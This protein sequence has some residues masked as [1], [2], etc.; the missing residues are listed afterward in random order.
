MFCSNCGLKLPENIKFC[1]KCGARII[2]NQL[3]ER[4]RNTSERGSKKLSEEQ[5]V[6]EKGVSVNLAIK[7]DILS[8]ASQ[9]SQIPS[10][11]TGKKE[12]FVQL[13]AVLVTG[14][15]IGGMLYLWKLEEGITAL[16]ITALVLIALG[17]ILYYGA[18]HKIKR[19]YIIQE[20]IYTD[21]VGC[22]VNTP[23]ELYNML[24]ANVSGLRIKNV[25]MDA[26]GG[27]N[28]ER[29]GFVHNFYM[30]NG[31]AK[32]RY[33]EK[34]VIIGR[35]IYG[36]IR[37]MMLYKKVQRLMDANQIMDFL[38]TRSPQFSTSALAH[39][40]NYHKLSTWKKMM[41]VGLA[42][43]VLGVILICVVA[44][45]DTKLED[46]ISSGEYTAENESENAVGEKTAE[47]KEKTVFYYRALDYVTLG[48][49]S[50]LTVEVDKNDC[51]VDDTT[52]YNYVDQQIAEA[53][54]N[55]GGDH[56]KT[57]VGQGDEVLVDYEGK[58]DGAAF[59][60][61][62][63]S[64]V[65]LDTDNAAAYVEGFTDNLVGAYIGDTVEQEVTFPDNYSTPELAGKK[66]VF[67]FQVKSVAEKLTHEMVDD[68]FI[69]D[70]FDAATLEEFIANARKTLE[71]EA[72]DN[73]KINGMGAAVL[74]VGEVSSFP[75]GVAEA[76]EESQISYYRYYAKQN[77]ISMEE[78]ANT[79]YSL[80]EEELLSQTKESVQQNLKQ[81]LI[82]E[83][84][85]ERE[86]LDNRGFQQY[87]SETIKLEG[88]NSEKEYY[89][90]YGE[91]YGMD[92]ELVKQYL[93][94][95]Y[96]ANLASDYL[97]ERAEISYTS[98]GDTG[99]AENEEVFNNEYTYENEYGHYTENGILED[100]DICGTYTGAGSLS[101]VTINIYTSYDSEYVGNVNGAIGSTENRDMSYSVDGEI[102]KVTDNVYRL[103]TQY[104]TV[105]DFCTYKND[106]EILIDVYT[107]GDVFATLIM[108][109]HYD[110]P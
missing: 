7:Q 89:E 99:D 75:E 83:A 51:T 19:E 41:P 88:I 81:Q 25:N 97:A 90:R 30:E 1:P 106:G 39:T 36:S 61:G 9:D 108:Q 58:I 96:L 24:L 35:S 92:E 2:T 28:V 42:S 6:Q 49:Y 63:A 50:S 5:A 14:A 70:N 27:V 20:Q 31:T 76:M 34:P 59:E 21:G 3:D 105:Y 64:D 86:K 18:Y 54:R 79:Y 48:D 56:A 65:W 43:I 23:V 16:T 104:G 68:V 74:K 103:E 62:S 26:A 38:V 60:G 12:Y 8:M 47:T 100:H 33:P 29:N 17:F 4:S 87:L 71:K 66:A 72:E 11:K 52:L 32:I 13:F 98:A 55:A 57:Y 109:E 107:N 82:L 69:S 91:I 73:A 44:M 77:N 22:G 102:K 101:G 94:K 46:K 37:Q 110:M 80:S 78:L 53:S 45:W 67:T 93:E 95:Q 10:G 84:V 40:E 15:Y 85:A